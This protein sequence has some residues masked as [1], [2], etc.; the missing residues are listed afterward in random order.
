MTVLHAESG[1]TLNQSGAIARLS[2][3]YSLRVDLLESWL[4]RVA[5]VPEHGFTVENS[6]MVAPDGD[7]PWEGRPRLDTS[8]FNCQAIEIDQAAVVLRSDSMRVRMQAAPLALEISQWRNGGWS[9][10]MQDRPMAAY[11]YLEQR[12]QLLHAQT[13]RVADRHLGLGDKSGSIDRTGRRVRCLQTDAL[14]Y[15][16]ET[17]DPLYKHVPWII[18]G[19]DSNDYCGIFYDTLAELAIDLGAEHSNYHDHYRSVEVYE[20]AL[21][22]YVVCGPEL[23]SVVPRFQQLVGKPHLQPRWS[24]GF[25]FTSMHHAD[26]DNAQAVML[27]FIRE[28]RQRDIPISALHSGS[29]YT[30][31]EDGRRYVFTWNTRKF[32]DRDGFFNALRQAG[33]HSCANIKPVLLTE[34]PSFAEVAAFDGFIT[35]ADGKPAIEMFWG[36]PGASLDFTNP[37]TVAW[38]QNGVRSQVLGAGFTAT[39]NDNN[40]CELWD[41][42]AGLHGFGHRLPAMQ[43]R[44]LQALLMIRASFEAAIERQ[45]GLRPYTISRAGPV[46]ISRYA[47]TWSGDNKTSWHTL[48]WNLANGLSMS[49]SGLPLHGHDIGGFDGPRPTAEL[50]CRWV[51]MMALHPRAVMNSWKPDADMEVESASGAAPPAEES[52]ATLPWMHE[53]VEAHVRHNLRLRYRFLPWIYHLS[54]CA[55]CQGTPVVVPLEYYYQEPQSIGEQTQFLL[56]ESVLVAPVIEEGAVARQVYLP[57][58]SAIW[59]E[60]KPGVTLDASDNTPRSV[61]RGGRVVTVAA[62]PGDLPVF[63]REGA[64]LPIAQEWPDH[65][66]HN[67]IIVCVTIFAIAAGGLLEQE[68][69]YDDGESWDFQRGTAQTI[70]VSVECGEQRVQ[71]KAPSRWPAEGGPVVEI[72][73]VGLAGRKLE[74]IRHE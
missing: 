57:D 24:A 18:V 9:T 63:V 2:A 32:P 16:A 49:L 7:V 31:G 67:A 15:D 65:Q 41:E 21:V 48:R 28:C 43:V 47:Q 61:H 14:G 72:A 58:D 62:E 68:L 12:G 3:G 27:D 6:W 13:R 69:F 40:E 66:P 29:G 23:S 56:G 10:I 34:H 38:W 22:Y 11:R 30:T 33:L 46:G 39:W 4:C 50:L 37:D 54:W 8:G 51:E 17:S 64:V 59:Y 25:A 5:I 73:V 45:P 20:D 36:G 70:T 35:D 74:L 26:S 52:R 53:S 71:V 44:P 1:F 60:W 42:Q 55:H 19:D